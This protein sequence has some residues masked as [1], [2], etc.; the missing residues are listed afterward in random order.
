MPVLSVAERLAGLLVRCHRRCDFEVNAALDE[1]GCRPAPGTSV[2]DAVPDLV[3][4]VIATLL[5]LGGHLVLHASAFAL[6]ARGG[7]PTAIGLLGESGSGKSTL[8]VLAWAAG[9]CLLTDDVLRIDDLSGEPRA[10]DGNGEVRL[11][12]ASADLLRAMGVPLIEHE[13]ADGRVAV[14]PRPVS[15]EPGDPTGGILDAAALGCFLVPVR[16]TSLAAL[17]LTRLSG[18]D[19]LLPLAKSPRISGWRGR[20][21]LAVHFEGTRLLAEKVPVYRAEL[22]E[23][24]SSP[25]DAARELLDL[26]GARL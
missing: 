20:R 24:A 21:Y 3:G 14:R 9:A 18:L 12:L 25:L 16:V 5:C 17:R 15:L 4:S 13:A 11:R 2:T 7:A 1:V 8:T 26:V 22:P 23:R 6:V 10:A 19:S